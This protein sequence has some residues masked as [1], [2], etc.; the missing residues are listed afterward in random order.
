MSVSQSD[1]HCALRAP[2]QT[3]PIGLTDALNQ[4]AEKRF[5]VYRNNVATSLMDALE[6]SFPVTQRLLGTE[7]FRNIARDFQWTRPPSTPLM[8]HYGA[9]FPEHLETLPALARFPYLGDV[10]RLEIALRQSYHAADSTAID[11]ATLQTPDL[12]NARFEFAPAMRIIS[13]PWPVL[14]IWRFNTQEG[15]AK[16][17]AKSE[18]VLVTRPDFDSVPI[19]ITAAD[20]ALIGALLARE[21]LSEALTAAQNTDPNHDFSHILGH[22]LAG[23]AITDLQ[24]KDA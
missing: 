6:S 21:P 13:S 14:S 20:T 16:P 5:N 2:D 24:F 4:T 23:R 7:N 18:H 17:V 3:I 8:M 1:F 22:L 10:A 15:A 12:I 19:E 11:P 9:D